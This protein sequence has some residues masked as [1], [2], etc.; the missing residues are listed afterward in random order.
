MTNRDTE[1]GFGTEI[2]YNFPG[3]FDD[4]NEA[5]D[6]FHAQQDK[7]ERFE[8]L[9]NNN[10]LNGIHNILRKKYKDAPITV[11]DVFAVIRDNGYLSD[12]F[13][14]ACFNLTVSDVRR[15]LEKGL[16]P[17]SIKSTLSQYFNIQ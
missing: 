5:Q 3:D 8:R 2:E 1:T 7:K 11:L 13:L 17:A 6:R 12:D 4:L 15:A 9:C 10:A 16:I 14:K